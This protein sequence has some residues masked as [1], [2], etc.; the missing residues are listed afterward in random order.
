MQ[1]SQYPTQISMK[2]QSVK[3]SQ[4]HCHYFLSVRHDTT[5]TL[6]HKCYVRT[7]KISFACSKRALDDSDLRL[8]IMRTTMYTKY[9]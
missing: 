9:I 3:K 7:S 4:L 5:Y 1:V 8:E 2:H 6:E